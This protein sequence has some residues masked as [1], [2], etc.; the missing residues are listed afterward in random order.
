MR[1]SDAKEVALH[2]W[3]AFGVALVI[4]TLA[5]VGWKG[6]SAFGSD[7][8]DGPNLDDMEAIEASLAYKKAEPKKQPQKKKNAP[9]P[10]EKIEGVSRDDQKDPVEPKKDEP[11]KTPDEETDPLA[12]FRRDNDDDLD[13]GK[14]KDEDVGQFDGS[15]FGFA[16]VTKGDEYW[17]H[18][19]ADMRWEYPELLAGEG[20]PVGCIHLEL[21]GKVAEI[22]LHTKSGNDELDDSVE[23]ALK[24]LKK[25][26]DDEP[27]AVPDR[28]QKQTR[29]W[30]CFKF[31]VQ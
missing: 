4:G 7:D 23:R 29:K 21:D 26:R 2:A 1:P 19:I 20:V 11:K 18:L 24:T 12:K 10:E 3:S 17:Q 13:T 27:V 6:A 30:I 28:L 5:L 25:S 9:Q 8:D 14:T 31:T 16:D 22:K 15:E